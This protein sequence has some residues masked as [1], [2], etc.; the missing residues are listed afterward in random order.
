M[1]IFGREFYLP[2]SALLSFVL[3]VGVL[4][5]M[6][7]LLCRCAKL[8][9]HQAV[10]LSEERGRV[11]SCEQV[12]VIMNVYSRKLRCY[13]TKMSTSIVEHYFVVGISSVSPKAGRKEGRIRYD[14]LKELTH[15]IDYTGH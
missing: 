2:F 5:V 3:A 8:L 12:D 15:S 6:S 11:R 1:V 9:E 13:D 10:D 14:R 7:I 4:E